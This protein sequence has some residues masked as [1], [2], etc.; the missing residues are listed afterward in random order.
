MESIKR[1]IEVINRYGR[2]SGARIN[3]KKSE[4]L[5]INVAEPPRDNSQFKIQEKHVKILGAYIGKND[6]EACNLSWTEALNKM[7]NALNL[8]KMRDLRLKGRVVVL[9]SLILSRIN[10]IIS[11]LQLPLWALNKINEMITNFLWRARVGK[12]A[13]KTL[14]GKYDEGGLKLID[15]ESKK[16]AFRIKTVRKYLDQ[17]VTFGWKSLMTYFLNEALHIGD[18]V[19]L[20][21]TRKPMSVGLPGFYREI[22]AAQARFLKHVDYQCD[23]LNDMKIVPIFLNEKLKY[24]GKILE[25]RSMIRA[26]IIQLKD[27]MLEVIPGFLPPHAVHDMVREIDEEVRLSTVTTSYGKIKES[28]PLEW[29]D[30]I[31][32][33]VKE[34][35]QAKLPTLWV[36]QG[37]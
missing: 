34:S 13:R 35:A 4:M 5:C 16:N 22:L 9:N 26:G 19:L 14:I 18:A 33:E 24:A 11:V 37:G 3:T 1:A 6:N 8:W 20:M 27:I 10:Y 21:Q 36:E 31:N 32:N 29:R 25:D 7:Q 23:N 28:V 15:V 30:K 17:E 2:A 12:I